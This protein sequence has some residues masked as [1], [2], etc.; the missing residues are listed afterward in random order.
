MVTCEFTLNYNHVKEVLGEN[1]RI[2]FPSQLIPMV[3]G[4]CGLVRVSYLRI[5]QWRSPTDSKPSLDS[6]PSTPT[7]KV[8][9]PKGKSF[10]KIFAPATQYSAS[11][12]LE[13][14]GKRPNIEDDK[15]D[16][17]MVGKPPWWRY[18]VS[19][20]PWLQAATQWW[21]TRNDPSSPTHRNIHGNGEKLVPTTTLEMERDLE[22]GRDERRET[23]Q[24]DQTLTAQETRKSKQSVP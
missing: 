21:K 10:F 8:T 23:W 16:E 1:G 3:I 14:E 15:V 20:L 12:H 17:E 18:L 24:T 5:G 4:A 11:G 6:V 7:R 19:W 2:F 13:G 22:K 9:L